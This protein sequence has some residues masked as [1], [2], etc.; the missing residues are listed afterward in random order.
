M[1]I[2][3]RIVFENI[4]TFT[5]AEGRHVS[6]QFQICLS[7]LPINNLITESLFGFSHKKQFKVKRDKVA[8]LVPTSWDVAIQTIGGDVHLGKGMGGV[9][10]I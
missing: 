1:K 10:G 4:A 2:C 9:L 6:E 8:Y 7:N 5:I 3:Q